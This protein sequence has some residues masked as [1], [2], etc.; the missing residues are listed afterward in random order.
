MRLRLVQPLRAGEG[1]TKVTKGDLD[2]VRLFGR[3][4]KPLALGMMMLMVTLTVYNVTHSSAFGELILGD[5]VA[6]LAG[7]AAVT[8]FLGW[9]RESQRMAEAGLLLAA[10][11]YVTRSAFLLFV[12][13][14]VTEGVYLGLGAAV[15]AGGAFLLES[16]DERT[17]D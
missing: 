2:G 11:V 3:P 1:L 7:T 10:T 14:P 12:G 9:L 17:G 15:M 16:W 5:V 4:L 8:L 6:V 13:G